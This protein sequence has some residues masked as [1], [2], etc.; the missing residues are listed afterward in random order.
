M[1]QQAWQLRGSLV[2]FLPPP[3]PNLSN[4][5]RFPSP[6]RSAR[7]P[8]TLAP[9][10]PREQAAAPKV[11]C[12]RAIVSRTRLHRARSS[13][14]RRQ[15]GSSDTT[16][17]S[18]YLQRARGKWAQSQGHEQRTGRALR[19]CLPVLEPHHGDFRPWLHCAQ[20]G[21]ASAVLQPLRQGCRIRRRG[22]N[23]ER[24]NPV[25]VSFK[26]R[27]RL[28]LQSACV[29]LSSKLIWLVR[30]F[31]PCWSSLRLWWVLLLHAR[32]YNTV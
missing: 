17:Q 27:L 32:V 11:P 7:F 6:A 30:C 13:I 31:T 29:L 18:R 10:K 1:V 21:L 20:T 19:G 2:P 16:S 23:V 24:L 5:P 9:A 25:S 22:R 26:P 15:R 3:A 12:T 28:R 14:L 8:S 4:A